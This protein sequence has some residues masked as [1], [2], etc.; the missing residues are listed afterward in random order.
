MKTLTRRMLAL[1]ALSACTT[2]ALGQ[3]FPSKPVRIVVPYA[4]GGTTD[5]LARFLGQRLS[6][7]I[8]QPVVVDNRPGAAEAVGAGLVAK[9]P[10]DGYT[11]LLCTL[12]TQAINPTLFPKLSFDATRELTAIGRVADVPGMVAVH[13]G[14]PAKDMAEF[15]AYLKANPGRNY[16]SP[17][18]GTPN[19]L[20][21]ELFKKAAG[22]QAT[23]IPYKGGAPAVQ[24]LMAGQVDF[25]LILAPEAAPLIATNK[26]RGL[27]V[28]SLQRS[29]MFPNLPTASEAGV[30]NFEMVVWYTLLAPASTPKDIVTKLNRSLNQVLGEK[31]TQDKLAELSIKPAG[32]TPEEAMAH[33]AR[34]ADKWRK[35]IADANIRAEN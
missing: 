9:S 24:D 35:V 27:A 6:E 16:A 17:G 18:A 4:P 3:D 20:A 29:P 14:V 19:H 22:V 31:Q 1:L 10:G 30:P 12:T 34:E 25:M 28:T 7:N 2:L 11:L 13:P 5:V 21:T 8:G 32:G 26:L 33:A 15:L 23:H